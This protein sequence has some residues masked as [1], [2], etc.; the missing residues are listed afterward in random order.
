MKSIRKISNIPVDKKLHKLKVIVVD[1]ENAFDLVPSECVLSP[2]SSCSVQIVFLPRLTSAQNKNPNN[3]VLARDFSAIVGVE[4]VEKVS[5][6]IL[7]SGTLTLTGHAVPLLFKVTPSFLDFHRSFPNQKKSQT[8]LLENLGKTLA[9][10][11]RLPSRL[12]HFHVDLEEI[13]LA[14]GES[15]PVTV[16]YAPNQLGTH[17]CDFLITVCSEITTINEK[18]RI[19]RVSRLPIRACCV[20]RYHVN[21]RGD[22]QITIL[23]TQTTENST[24]TDELLPST[25]FDGEDIAA[26]D[27]LPC[28]PSSCLKASKQA[29]D[30]SLLLGFLPEINLFSNAEWTKHVHHRQRYIDYI[31]NHR[32]RR[33]RSKMMLHGQLDDIQEFVKKTE[34]ELLEAWHAMDSQNGLIPPSDGLE[35]ILANDLLSDQHSPQRKKHQ[36]LLKSTFGGEGVGVPLNAGKLRQSKAEVTLDPSSR[37]SNAR[38]ISRD[39]VQDDRK[40]AFL[41]D[42][43]HDSAV[44]SSQSSV[45]AS[46][47][48]RFSS[49]A[50]A[51]SEHLSIDAKS[52]GHLTATELASIFTSTDSIDFGSCTQHSV[53]SAMLKFL[54]VMPSG[55]SIHVSVALVPHNLNLNA[56]ETKQNGRTD[57]DLPLSLDAYLKITPSC[58][59]VSS[60][61]VGGFRV[62]MKVDSLP[63]DSSNVSS[64]SKLPHFLFVASLA[65]TVNH[66]Y[67]YQIPVTARLNP[68]DLVWD[69][70]TLAVLDNNGSRLVVPVVFHNDKNSADNDG[71]RF[72]LDS[73]DFN[74]LSVPS[75]LERVVTLS[76]PGLFCHIL[77]IPQGS[78]LNFTR[79]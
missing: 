65:F 16:V 71:A 46:S 66:R 35:R 19:I 41:F 67:T 58:L 63:V 3:L 47:A 5:G 75:Q 7:N 42:Q 23:D 68:V 55:G 73:G 51:S 70:S 49:I 15:R 53:N 37:S 18:P 79:H 50:N 27:N 8:F 2:F 57:E 78:T 31:R 34:H 54:N 33:L 12:A 40:I 25:S 28:S 76:N 20:P 44:L 29:V 24:G 48:T 72:K 43:L 30:S 45:E 64:D 38:K 36:K 4:A 1:D 39:W 59:D 61:S 13:T 32:Q 62:S 52:T 69:A 11:L 22:S 9:I 14:A 17:T 10:R 26:L 77:L 6:H 21:S 60:M 56:S 74:K